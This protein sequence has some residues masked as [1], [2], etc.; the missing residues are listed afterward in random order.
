MSTPASQSRMNTMTATHTRAIHEHSFSV[1]L[2]AAE[3]FTLFEPVGEM[4]WAEDWFPIFATASDAQL[5]E[6]SIFTVLRPGPDGEPP[7]S[8]VWTVTRYVPSRLI[9]YH[10]VIIGQR[11]TRITVQ[12]AAEGDRR[13]TV[14]VRYVYTGLTDAGD[15]AISQITPTSYRQMIDGWSAAIAAWLVRGTPASGRDL[16]AVARAENDR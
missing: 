10:N 6:G 15:K 4:C 11:A 14:V 16:I 13:T 9:E 7:I 1:P 2:P 12:C 3:A 8:S 5:H